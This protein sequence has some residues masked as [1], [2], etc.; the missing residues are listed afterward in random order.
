MNSKNSSTK[1]SDSNQLSLDDKR[2]LEMALKSADAGLWHIDVINN[3]NQ[4]D[5]RCLAVFGTSRASFDNSYEAW[6]N[7]VHP[8]DLPASEKNY[9][10]CLKTGDHY[11]DVHRV[12]HPDGSIHFVHATGSITQNEHGISVRVTGLVFDITDKQDAEVKRVTELNKL[13]ESQQRLQ[14][15]IKN[16]VD[17]II[18]INN[19]GYI[20]TFNLAAENMFG[21]SAKEVIGKNVR[22]LMDSFHSVKHDNYLKHH[23]S[24]GE[25]TII[26]VGRELKG[27]RKDDSLF[28]MELAISEFTL[29]SGFIFT[30]IVR[31]ISQRKNLEGQLL[32]SQK[33]EALGT[34]A[35]GIAHDFNNILA[36]ITGN[37]ELAKMN[38][39]NTSSTRQNINNIINTSEQAAKLIKQIMTFSRMSTTK[40]SV[41]NLREAITWAVEMIATMIPVGIVFKKDFVD[42]ERC[43]INADESQIQQVILNLFTNA[44]FSMKNKR[45]S[46][47]IRLREASGVLSRVLNDKAKYIEL[48]IRDEGE[49]IASKDID[50]IFDPFFTTK[51]VGEG[52]GL[53]LSVVHS[54][55]RKHHGDIRVESEKGKGTCLF[56]YFPR[57]TEIMPS[58]AIKK[59]EFDD[60]NHVGNILIVE[61]EPALSEVY[62]EFL[63]MKGFNITVCCCGEDALRVFRNDINKFDL[64]LTDYS[65]PNMTGKQLSKE[66]LKI[67]SGIPILLA[68]GFGDIVSAN[69]I[70]KLGIKH[71]LIKPIKL[72]KLHQVIDEC[73]MKRVSLN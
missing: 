57:I 49:G 8:E 12:I 27:K 48:T 63:E 25:N 67:K 44:I 72:S 1:F 7:L 60:A 32:Q 52:T 21:Y 59:E 56:L 45:G 50:K 9:M 42:F 6:A 71:C 70:N 14:A 20:D 30:G 10:H 5:D 22:I 37:A 29:D 24:T 28:P 3:V 40:I 66:L 17:G 62:K 23:I 18:T 15:I 26:G 38:A 19:E 65:M 31:D 35:G 2:R 39:E 34:L 36:I 11:D 53:G 68:T 46:I 61:D 69:E 13:W 16:T 54:I 43:I 64:V 51:K 55:V 4:W 47:N 73:L 41:M 33:M 58:I